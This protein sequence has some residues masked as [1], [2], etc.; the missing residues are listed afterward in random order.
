MKSPNKSEFIKKELYDNRLML[1]YIL[2]YEYNNDS[3]NAIKAF[4]LGQFYLICNKFVEAYEYLTKAIHLEGI[5][6]KNCF[7]KNVPNSLFSSHL[8]K[9][10]FERGKCFYAQKR[11]DEA[12]NDYTN[13]INSENYKL[14]I[15]VETNRSVTEHMSLEKKYNFIKNVSK[16]MYTELIMGSYNSVSYKLNLLDYYFERA[17]LYLRCYKMDIFTFKLRIDFYNKAMDDYF[18][19]LKEVLKEVFN[20]NCKKKYKYYL[21]KILYALCEYNQEQTIYDQVTNYPNDFAI[22][23]YSEIL[24]HII[25]KN[26][27]PEKLNLKRVHY[28]K[29]RGDLYS[30]LEQYKA[31]INDYSEILNLLPE[32]NAFGNFNIDRLFYHEVRGDLYLK[33]KEFEEAISD[34][35]HV[36]ENSDNIGVFCKRA[37]AFKD[38]R[39]NI[40]FSLSDKNISFLPDKYTS[41]TMCNN[42]NNLTI[43]IKNNSK[44]LFEKNT[45]FGER[46]RKCNLIAQENKWNI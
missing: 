3:D 1:Y 12:L 9:F 21:N 42:K 44:N 31:A 2:W 30:K 22:K 32:K 46:I 38:Q 6:L 10:Y 25:L 13:A 4:R 14:K 7:F 39:N 40:S 35:T 28:L 26:E 8:E 23:I 45:S 43:S 37:N 36:L 19:S 15:L 41:K 34:Y 27:E 20:P 16:I 33:I 5:K 18:S 17:Q 11:F 29:V 24:A